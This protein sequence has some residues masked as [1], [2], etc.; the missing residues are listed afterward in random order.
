MKPFLLPIVGDGV[1]K[2]A[3]IGRVERFELSLFAQRRIGV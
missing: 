3:A 2:L 1:D